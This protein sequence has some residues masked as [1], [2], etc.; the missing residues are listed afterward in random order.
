[1]SQ[2]GS[3]GHVTTQRGSGIPRS[4]P[5]LVHPAVMLVERIERMWENDKQVT[6]DRA[7][8]IVQRLI[9]MGHIAGKMHVDTPLELDPNGEA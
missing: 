2:P 8:L 9:E 3:P 1:M 7:R 6:G 5:R 4:N